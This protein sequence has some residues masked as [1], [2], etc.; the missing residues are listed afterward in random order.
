MYRE[1]FHFYSISSLII[2]YWADGLW[3]QSQPNKMGPV[4]PVFLLIIIII[5][6][7]TDYTATEQML[8]DTVVRCRLWLNVEGTLETVYRDGRIVVARSSL[9]QSRMV[10][11]RKEFTCQFWFQ[12]LCRPRTW[13]TGSSVLHLYRMKF[14]RCD[15]WRLPSVNL[16][17]MALSGV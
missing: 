10:L 13:S 3:N 6:I 9:F 1:N 15:C 14:S 7:I 8:Q 11:G 16:V 17:E 12:W 2:F 5:I 4:R